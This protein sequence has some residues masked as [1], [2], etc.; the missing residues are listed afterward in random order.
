MDFQQIF[1]VT[2]SIWKC[3]IVI[4]LILFVPFISQRI[5]FPQIAGLIL[6]GL[7]VGGS[8]LNIIDTDEVLSMC[9]KICLLF[10][11]FFA[12]LDIDIE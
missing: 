8:G 4:A 7:L 9:S 6:A 11:M 3:F 12:G 5:R 10:I 1:P 2:D